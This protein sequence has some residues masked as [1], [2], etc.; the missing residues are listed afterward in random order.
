MSITTRRDFVR[1][2][3][4]GAIGSGLLP[5]ALRGDVAQTQPMS[6]ADSAAA[7]SRALR[8]LILGGTGFIG[9]HLV[10]AVLARGHTPVL[11]N[12]GRT[13]PQMFAEQYIGLENLVGDRDGDISALSGGR[14]DAV[15][16][17]SGYTPEQVRATARLLRGSVGHYVFTSTRA[18][19]RDFTPAHVDEDSPVGMRG[20]PDTEWTGYGPLKA[21]AEREV[22]QAF[23]GR[24]TIARPPIITGPGDSTDRFTYWYA[25]IDRGGEVLAPGD[26]S[27]PVQYID[28]RDLVDFYMHVVEQRVHGVFNTVAPAAPLSSA[29]F[30]YGVRAVTAVPVTFTWADWDFLETHGIREG[31]ELSAW[32]APRG[33]NLNYGR[34]DNSRA[35]AAGMTFRPLAV[36]AADTLEW[37]HSLPAARRAGSRAGIPAAAERAALAARASRRAGTR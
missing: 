30:L 8:I 26:P 33:D 10:R 32:R 1:T 36:T 31:R 28:V 15:I 16:D 5:G 11:F 24:H 17:D 35:V 27:D 29:E 25:R 37:W 19:Y 34:V 3:A 7:P 6:S 18:V 21:L 13:E 12:R 20:V 9:P 23:D 22:R 14:W 2:A 4:I